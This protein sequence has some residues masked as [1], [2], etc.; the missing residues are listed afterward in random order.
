MDIIAMGDFAITNSDGRSCW[1]FRMPSVEEID[2]VKEIR[3]HNR[4]YRDLLVS[5]EE[6]RKLRNKAKRDR[7]R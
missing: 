4:K 7:R 2:F 5:A 6:K 3:E 1:T